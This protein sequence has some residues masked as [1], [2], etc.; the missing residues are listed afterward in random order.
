MLLPLMRERVLRAKSAASGPAGSIAM[1]REA[2]LS[3]SRPF[4]AVALEG[5]SP[6]PTERAGTDERVA[7][8][9]LLPTER[10]GDNVG[11]PSWRVDLALT[12]TGAASVAVAAT[13]SG[14]V[15]A[16]VDVGGV[17]AAR[18]T[19]LALVGT[20]GQQDLALASSLAVAA[21]AAA[22]A[23]RA[24]L[25]LDGRAAAAGDEPTSPLAEPWATAVATDRVFAG[26]VVAIEAPAGATAGSGA[27]AA[28]GGTREARP[29]DDIRLLDDATRSSSESEH[30]SQLLVSSSD[31]AASAPAAAAVAAAT[32]AAAP[33]GGPAGAVMGVT[34]ES[35]GRRCGDGAATT[36]TGTGPGTDAANAAG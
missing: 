35:A 28:T 25:A 14:A 12:G 21:V 6:A 32:A 22:P 18:P 15:P 3:A 10:V 27:A 16:A 33:G 1:E 30:V 9:L 7:L 23:G 24:D 26:D 29:L 2:L 4:A 34:T 36:G 17:N 5:V 13:R 31:A 8:L 19:D 11:V 20:P